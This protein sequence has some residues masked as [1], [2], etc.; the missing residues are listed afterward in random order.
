MYSVSRVGFTD[1]K[2]SIQLPVV[3]LSSATS[4]D[5]RDSPTTNTH[6]FDQR[7]EIFVVKAR[8]ISSKLFLTLY[9]LENDFSTRDTDDT[10]Y[11]SE[12]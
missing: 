3:D 8:K 10:V 7:Q 12:S 5:V 1:K 11:H 6:T 2:S 9:R 4:A